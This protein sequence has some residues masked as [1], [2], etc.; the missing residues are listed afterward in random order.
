VTTA[1]V[2]H[3]DIG[4][5]AE[6]VLIDGDLSQLSPEDRVKYYNAVCNSV[7]LNPLTKPFEYIKLNGKLRLYALRDC[8]DQLRKIHR[9]SV[10]IV[11]RDRSDDLYIVTA[12]ASTADGR[13]DESTGAVTIKNLAG[14]ALANAIMKAETKAKRR[15]TL[16]ICG[17]GMLDESEADSVPGAV[18]Q[19]VGTLGGAVDLN[20][21][22]SDAYNKTTQGD[23]RKFL[24]AAKQLSWDDKDADFWLYRR[25]KATW[26]KVPRDEFHKILE[27]MA[28]GE[29]RLDQFPPEAAPVIPMTHEPKVHYAETPEAAAKL[30]DTLQKASA[31]FDVQ[32][33]VLLSSDQETRIRAL[34]KGLGWDAARGKRFLAEEFAAAQVKDLTSRQAD[35][36]IAKLEAMTK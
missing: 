12:N 31:T 3:N 8:T 23:R 28:N 14:E 22:N 13:E 34:A 6:R 33:S 26:D 18:R 21:P 9:V 19:P 17:L 24:N 5:T 2:P 36:A 4:A 15:V 30:A 16:S 35:E 32:P 1:I 27:E 10:R 7:G 11:S 20:D 29:A 25:A